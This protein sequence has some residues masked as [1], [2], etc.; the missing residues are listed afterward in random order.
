MTEYSPKPDL[1]GVN[2]SDRDSRLKD[3]LILLSGFLVIVGV[4]YFT[5]VSVADWALARISLRTE[6]DWMQ[7]V[8]TKTESE[9]PLP[10]IVSQLAAQLSPYTEVPLQFSVNCSKEVNAFALPGGRIQLTRGLLQNLKTE[11][12]LLFVMG[13][14]LAHVVH[15]D[16]LRGMGRQ[17]V[18]A[19]G[20]AIFGMNDIGGL[21]AVNSMLLQVYSREQEASADDFALNVLGKVY[22]HTEGASELFEIILKEE[23]KVPAAFRKF[24]STHPATED[25][26]SRV[27]T[28]QGTSRGKISI[29]ALPEISFDK[30]CQSSP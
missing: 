11:N 30:L 27:R 7:K 21:S 10:P 6:R 19:V 14:E 2:S 18:T 3:V 8:W 4:F 15:R 16:H 1:E 5:L 26:I 23:A 28:S 20:A 22:G 25:R 13:H 9:P 24:S 29:K 12:G 17:L